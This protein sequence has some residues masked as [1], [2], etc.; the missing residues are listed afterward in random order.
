MNVITSGEQI[1]LISSHI[2]STVDTSKVLPNI[3]FR[4]AFKYFSFIT[5]DEPFL[6]IFFN[7]LK[8]FLV[9]IREEQFWLSAINLEKK[10]E[11]KSNFNITS[12]I[13][14]LTA[15]NE[16]DY[17]QAVNGFTDNDELSV[18]MHYSDLLIALSSSRKWVV[19]GDSVADIAICAFS[20]STYSDVF[21]A[22]YGTELLSIERAAEYA[23]GTASNL[24]QREK[25][26]FNYS[27]M[28]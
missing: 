17:L 1:D 15:D 6:P 21:K 5:F 13:Q 2:D 14:V 25:L 4:S 16:K 18:H 7:N 11:N 20:D 12:A 19:F 8:Q 23:Y 22:V 27:S 28:S 9:E 10:K 24:P 3:V 26:L